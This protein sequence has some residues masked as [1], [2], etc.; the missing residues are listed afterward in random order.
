MVMT[1]PPPSAQVAADPAGPIL[2]LRG[3]EKRFPGVVALSGVDLDL[4]PG[5]VTALIGEN[6]AGKSTIVKV[7]TGIY[8]PEAGTI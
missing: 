1:K 2:S 3:I 4:R 5:R 6:G 8:R 7:L